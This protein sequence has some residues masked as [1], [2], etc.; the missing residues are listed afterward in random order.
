[1]KTNLLGLPAVVLLLAIL[2]CNF[3]GLAS[4]S[5]ATPSNTPLSGSETPT[6]TLE[7]SLGLN[8]PR[9]IVDATGTAAAQAVEVTQQ[10]QEQIGN[11]AVQATATAFA[12]YLDQLTVFGIDPSQ[13]VPGWIHP[14]LTLEIEGYQQMQ[15]AEN[16]LSVVVEDFIVSA[17][18]TWYTEYG[19]SGCG[20]VLRSDGNQEAFNQY[21][22]M[23]TRSAGGH[24]VLLTMAN[25]LI[26]NILDIYATGQDPAFNWKNDGTN[27]LTVIGRGQAIS[28]YTNG[29]LLATLD[30]SVPPS[31]PYLPPEPQPPTSND[32]AAINAYKKAKAD[33]D[34]QV[35]KAWAEHNARLKLLKEYNTV[36]PRGFVALVALTESGFTRCQFTNAWLWRIEPQS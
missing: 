4:D 18:I 5:S 1:M 22:V 23:I 29:T 12:P 20:F 31:R 7:V 15:Y 21:V 36:F 13:G 30:P 34:K 2:A 10:A 35:A 24:A 33:Y 27:R 6:A 19:N 17:D 16:F 28:I 26:V 3:Q 11:E 25:G 8:I 32:P 9:H 14:P